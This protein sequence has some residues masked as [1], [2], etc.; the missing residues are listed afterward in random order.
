MTG[1]G[2]VEKPLI[3]PVPPVKRIGLNLGQEK[4]GS[5]DPK[6][7][8]KSPEPIGSMPPKLDVEA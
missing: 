6:K 5:P 2:R 7:R 4:K 3:Q 8:S 1:I